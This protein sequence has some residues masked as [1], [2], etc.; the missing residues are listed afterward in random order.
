MLSNWN[1]PSPVG[2]PELRGP[3]K[4]CSLHGG[5]GFIEK[6]YL[7]Y[8]LI[9]VPLVSGFIHYKATTAKALVR[10]LAYLFG[11]VSS[12]ADD[13]TIEIDE[14]TLG[15]ELVEPMSEPEEDGKKIDIGSFGQ[16]HHDVAALVVSD[17]YSQ[18]DG[19]SQR[20]IDVPSDPFF[21][22]ST[23]MIIYVWDGSKGKWY[24]S[25]RI[26]RMRQDAEVSVRSHQRDARGPEEPGEVPWVCEAPDH[27]EG[28]RGRARQ[29]GFGCVV[30]SG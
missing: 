19:I 15:F 26:R 21:L 30:D 9:L 8:V 13:T 3:L 18:G 25:E 5:I 17:T 12:Q 14:S 27:P 1:N 22:I 24:G 2:E 28:C 20:F 11:G 23:G 16:L 7:Y 6:E 4:D 10:G 29:A